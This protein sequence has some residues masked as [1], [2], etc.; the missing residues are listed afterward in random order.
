MVETLYSMNLDMNL[1]RNTLFLTI[2]YLDEYVSKLKS[3]DKFT[4]ENYVA[5]SYACF[6]MAQKF[7]EIYPPSIDEWLS[8]SF[9][10]RIFEE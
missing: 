2:H 4:S 9:H 10:K 3:N 8:K 6:L 5:W 1:K 7:E